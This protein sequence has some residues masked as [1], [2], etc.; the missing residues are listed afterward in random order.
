VLSAGI[1]RIENQ[2]CEIL[3]ELKNGAVKFERHEGE[4]KANKSG[5]VLTQR[6]LFAVI[7]VLVAAGGGLLAALMKG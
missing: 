1:E 5:I 7:G 2:T 4:L 3:L 6:I